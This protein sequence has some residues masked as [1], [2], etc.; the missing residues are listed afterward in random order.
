MRE[1]LHGINYIGYK[2]LTAVM[3]DRQNF[4]MMMTMTMI[5]FYKF[6]NK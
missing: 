6:K 5:Y 2:T 1:I 4:Y 3:Q